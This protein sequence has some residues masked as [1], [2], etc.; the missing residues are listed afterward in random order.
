MPKTGDL[1][2]AKYRIEQLIG[3]GG[4]G[5]VFSA[6]HQYTGKRVALK[7]MLPELAKDEDA[8]QRFMREA[9]AAGRISHPNVVDVYDVGQHDDSYFLVMEYL[10]G[11]PLTSA[12]ARRDLTP[13]EVLT[14]LM[15]A[16][17]GV[18]A[19]H[20][21]GVVH[22]D[23]K[24][25]NIFLAYEEDGV[26]REAKVLDFGISKLAS[27]DQSSMHLTRTG[28]V[29]GTPYYMS[30][31]QIRGKGEIDRRS[32]VYAF[33]VILYESLSGQVPF[34]AETYGALVLEIATGTPKPLT[35]LVPNVPVELSRIVLQAMAREVNARYPTMEDLIAALEVF[36]RPSMQGSWRASQRI[37]AGSGERPMFDGTHA[38]PP[39]ISLPLEPPVYSPTLPPA[40]DTRPSR[41]TT[42]FA[43]EARSRSA[44]TG[45]IYGIAGLLAVAAAIVA[46]ALYLTRDPEPDPEV[47]APFAPQP[48]ET[49]SAASTELQI[50]EIPRGVSAGAVQPADAAHG[51]SNSEANTTPEVAPASPQ[52]LSK[53][54]RRDSHRNSG[55]HSR[56][57]ADTDR[58][59]DKDKHVDQ[60]PRVIPG[61]TD[62]PEPS[63]AAP[64]RESRQSQQQRARSGSLNV[65]EF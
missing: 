47:V 6:T 49:K 40:V 13:T 63:P 5:A 57:S 50:E 36:T 59:R 14:L 18:A 30:P 12:L 65:N 22:R 28:A 23:L 38:A 33:G 26:R 29:I 48:A 45:R 58:E 55:A 51:G 34:M 31:E 25:D 60:Q 32:D 1:I 24:P 16:M 4:M 53:E 27:D 62:T 61:V 35:E 37:H 64:P 20:R 7:W 21:Q 2:A 8:V 43:A 42:P 41:A 46:A 19:A 15:P 44:A 10:H 9:R 52:R 17:R 11:E 56:K 39:R 3:V 54:S